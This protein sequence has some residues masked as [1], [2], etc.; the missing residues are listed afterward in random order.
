MP[1]EKKYTFK[2]VDSED[3]EDILL[4]IEDSFGFKFEQNELIHTETFGELCDIVIGK[5]ELVH[6]DDCTS[7]QAFYKIREAICSTLQL[8]KSTVTPKTRI[9]EIFPRQ[10]RRQ[11]LKD[12]EDYLDLKLKILQPK[13]LLTASLL[14]LLL[15][16]IIGI[17]INWKYGL[18]GIAFSVLGLSLVIHYANE[19]KLKTIGELADYM[20][21]EN[22]KRSRRDSQTM[23]K[24]EI[25][26]KIRSLFKDYL[27]LAD[28]ELQRDSKFQ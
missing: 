26:G 6:V 18:G 22:Y 7:Q 14:I 13:A 16:S 1:K 5:I 9:T 21:R 3:I 17:F 25:E 11:R 27:D 4:K 23:N 28:S 2:N 19:I 12:V 24:S 8:E 20:S 15:F 10:K